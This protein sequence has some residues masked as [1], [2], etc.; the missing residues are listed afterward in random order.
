ML[1]LWAVYYVYYYKNKVAFENLSDVEFKDETFRNSVARY[2]S[3]DFY[4][5]KN[6]PNSY[7]QS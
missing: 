7:L 5:G 2:L 1:P 6:N 3:M 4:L